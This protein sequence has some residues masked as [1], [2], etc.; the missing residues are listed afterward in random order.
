MHPDRTVSSI[1]ISGFILSILFLLAIAA[2]PLIA[3]AKAEDRFHQVIDVSGLEE[4]ALETVN[5]SIEVTG[6]DGDQVTLDATLKVEGRNE[7]KCRELLEKIKI[8]IEKKNKTLEIDYDAKSKRGY[9]IMVSYTLLAPSRMKIDAETVNGSID[10][11][12]INGGVDAET[13]NG[14]IHCVEIKG[15][16]SA[17]TINGGIEFENSTGE[18]HAEAI[19]GGIS[20]INEK[21]APESVDC[22]TI[23]GAI[24]IE[25]QRTPDARIS[26]EAM[27]GRIKVIGLPDV[28]LKKRAKSFNSLLGSGKGRYELNTINGSITIDVKGAD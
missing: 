25:L 27:N 1:P 16:A 9:S 13:I 15:R 26:A 2:Q 23:N 21:D 6:C 10:L 19:N 8:E 5:G 4:V 22:E 24:S 11:K 7:E 12:K 20:C 17:E 18:I 14:G 28:K 3:K